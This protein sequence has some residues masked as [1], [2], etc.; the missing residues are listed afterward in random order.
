MNAYD[1]LVAKTVATL[2]DTHTKGFYNK[3]N[4]DV[5]GFKKA[6]VKNLGDA[7]DLAGA[8]II[9]VGA[10]DRSANRVENRLDEKEIKKAEEISK[11]ASTIQDVLVVAGDL[12]DALGKY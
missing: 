7:A 4:E 11:T 12:A 9:G 2:F 1:R 8:A 5:F 6:K 10:M 3:V